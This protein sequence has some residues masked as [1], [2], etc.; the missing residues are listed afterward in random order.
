MG[1]GQ[2]VFKG[3]PK[4]KKQKKP[5]HS[6]EKDDDAAIIRDAN[7][8]EPVSEIPSGGAVEQYPDASKSE[9]AS[10]RL[11]T[12]DSAGGNIMAPKIHKGTGKITSSG[13]VV[14][15]HGTQ[16][17]REINV[18]DAILVGPEM[19][20]VTM[21]LSDASI[22]L[23]TAFT[24]NLSRPSDFQYIHKPRSTQSKKSGDKAGQLKQEEQAAFGTFN[25]NNELIYHE[26]TEHGSYRIKR[27]KVEGDV[28]RTDLLAMRLKKTSDKYC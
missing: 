8:L 18:G 17:Q 22:N 6:L 21:R 4:K 15:G 3:E 9:D 2:L 10:G 7:N 11:T 1:R 16:F 14:T 27:Q 26:K 20:V 28:T 19:R 12:S 23:S 13:T 24:S 5:K 25:S